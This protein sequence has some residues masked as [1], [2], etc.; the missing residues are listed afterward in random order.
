MGQV[1]IKC[2]KTGK[3]VPTGMAMD[4]RA[5]EGSTLSNNAI[6]CPHCGQTHVW[7]KLDAWVEGD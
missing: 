1:V 3:S 2:P 5:F 4:K 6:G 7:S